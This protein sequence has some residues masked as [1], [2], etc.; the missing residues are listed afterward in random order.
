[1]IQVVCESGFT[2]TGQ[3]TSDYYG[4]SVAPLGDV[5]EDGCDDFAAGALG[6][7][8]GVGNQG[9]VQV[10]FGWGGVG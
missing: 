2:A 8:Y 7:D 6:W 3:A 1:M 4:V 5:N 10:F 9:G